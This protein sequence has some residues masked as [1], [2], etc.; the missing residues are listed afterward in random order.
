MS[1]KPIKSLRTVI[2]HTSLK[3]IVA[4]LCKLGICP[5]ILIPPSK[6]HD[7]EKEIRFKRENI[8]YKN[9]LTHNGTWHRFYHK[10]YFDI[11]NLLKIISDGTSIIDIG[12]NMGYFS[13]EIIKHFPSSQYVLYEPFPDTYSKLQQFIKTNRFQNFTAHNKGFDKQPGQL[14]F[15]AINSNSGQVRL[16]IDNEGE[17]VEVI[18]L[19]SLKSNFI[20]QNVFL[21]I[22]VEGME[23]RVIEGGR[24]FIETI[25]PKIYIECSDSNLIRLGSSAR[26]LASLLIKLQYELF[27][28][29]DFSKIKGTQVLNNKNTDLIC[30]HKNN[31]F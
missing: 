20:G 21:K 10:E 16:N 31:N 22:D 6:Q 26:A 2:A 7:P 23:Q 9:T 13:S 27:L 19:D 14:R 3:Q 17:V 28:A 18:K 29:D 1:F 30:I 5:N 24:D 11:K 12:A 25:K 15:K 4:F 8:I